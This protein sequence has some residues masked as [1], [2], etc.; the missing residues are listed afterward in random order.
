VIH[1]QLC[2]SYIAYNPFM[3]KKSISNPAWGL[4]VVLLVVAAVGI[5][6]HLR[7]PK[8]LVPW[9][10]D[11]AAA[12]TEAVAQHKPLF[13]DF[14][15]SWCPDCRQMAASTWSDRSVADALERYVPVSIDVDAHP[16]LAGR[17][18]VNSIP[19]VFV[20]DPKTGAVIKENRLGAIPPTQF[21]DWLRG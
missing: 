15:A 7:E 21:L 12:R 2:G 6:S 4:F 17:Y 10:S 1:I 9:R 16:D 14:G 20:V 11:L 5:A 13:L 18:Q 8:N 3:A 19:A